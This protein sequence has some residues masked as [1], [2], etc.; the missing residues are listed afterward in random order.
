[1]A[2]R[3]AAFVLGIIAPLS[4]GAAQEPAPPATSQTTAP[5]AAA[6]PATATV[7]LRKDTLIPLRLLETVSSDTHLRGAHFRLEVTDDISVDDVVVIPSGS[8][9]EG[10]VIHAAKSSVFGKAGELMITSRFVTLGARQVKLHALLAGTGQSRADLAF[11]VWPF[12]KG[13]KV[14]IPDGTE[15]IA[16]IANDETFTAPGVAP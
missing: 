13:K 14:I 6:A 11:F 15:L 7:V 5:T 9:A 3:R 16:K 8:I 10:E 4:L 1:M 2:S 12:I